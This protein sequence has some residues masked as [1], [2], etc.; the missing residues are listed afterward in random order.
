MKL[1]DDYQWFEDSVERWE[2]AQGSGAE[3]Q[4]VSFARTSDRTLAGLAALRMQEERNC[5]TAVSKGGA[6]APVAELR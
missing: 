3:K 2:I 5:A 1:V 4:W 6:A